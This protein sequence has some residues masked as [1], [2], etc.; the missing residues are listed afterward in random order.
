MK[1]AL[2]NA[3][4]ILK[5][6]MKAV[7]ANHNGKIEFEGQSCPPNPRKATEFSPE[8]RVFV[9]H[10]EAELWQLF[11]TIDRDHSG[12]LDKNELRIA[13]KRAGI[14][15]E[16]AKLAS[17]FDRIDA[18]N[19]GSISFEEWRFV[20]EGAPSA[21]LMR[22]CRDFLL[23]LPKHS[24]S[25]ETMFSYFSSSL[26]ISAEGDVHVVDENLQGL[27]TKILVPVLF[28]V[29]LRIAFGQPS[30][31]TSPQHNPKPSDDSPSKRDVL[32]VPV[33]DL[34]TFPWDPGERPEIDTMGPTDEDD[35][36]QMA[37]AEKTHGLTSLL[38]DPGYFLAGGI[39]GAISRTSTAP[40]DRLKVYLI[41]QT[42]IKKEAL[43]AVKSGSLGQAARHASRPLF[44]AAQALWKMGGMR[45]LFA[46]KQPI[47][48]INMVQSLHE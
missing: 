7:D 6:V 15:I 43:D 25:I 16:D 37:F 17:F 22:G 48:A 5:D 21:R 20:D 47:M 46:G 4:D 11:K 30:P 10:A 34:N 24:T 3:T 9:E 39:A 44:D 8:F 29:F 12:R 31:S 14:S 26:L 41:A 40:L 28:G 18:N 19:D 1:L 33:L 32:G 36:S 2:A 35:E 23:F 27:G 42:S 38:P 45:S 13:F